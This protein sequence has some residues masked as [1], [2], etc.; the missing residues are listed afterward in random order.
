MELAA[1]IPVVRL[2]IVEVRD[3]RTGYFIP[4]HYGM[5]SGQMEKLSVR[6]RRR[7]RRRR[8]LEIHIQ[9]MSFLNSTAKSQA[10]DRPIRSVSSS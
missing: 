9:N 8:H 5:G 1:A 10:P 7:R 6:R 4:V 2:Y 3:S